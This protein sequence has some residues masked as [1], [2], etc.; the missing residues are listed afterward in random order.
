MAMMNPMV[1]DLPEIGVSFEIVIK[2]TG[3]KA[4]ER[5][6]CRM[7]V[8][9]INEMLEERARPMVLRPVA[10]MLHLSITRNP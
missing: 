8:I 9:K 10:K 4:R 3:K 5:R 7:S 6:A 2:A 1:I